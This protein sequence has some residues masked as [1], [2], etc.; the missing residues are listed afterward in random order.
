[1]TAS[2]LKQKASATIISHRVCGETTGWLSQVTICSAESDGASLKQTLTAVAVGE[3]RSWLHEFVNA[4]TF[5][6]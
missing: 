2:M 1:M 4:D 3:S 6:V 5:L